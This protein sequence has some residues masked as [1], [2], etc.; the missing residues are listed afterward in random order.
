MPCAVAFGY[1]AMLTS[2]IPSRDNLILVVTPLAEEWHAMRPRLEDPRDEPTASVPVTVGRI[3]SADVVLA[4]SGKGQEHT[5]AIVTKLA[6]QYL[7]RYV[8]LVGVSGGFPKAA[9]GDV[10]IPTFV[11]SLD[12]GKVEQSAFIRRPELDYAP[13]H[14]LV[15]YAKNIIAD[16]RQNWTDTIRKDRPDGKARSATSVKVGYVASSNKVIDDPS[17]PAVAEALASTPE[18]LAVEMEA[19]GAWAAVKVLQSE[20]LIGLLMVR[21]IS[22]MPGDS[23]TATGAGTDSRLH[24]KPYAADS[25][26]AFA[27]AVIRR[28]FPVDPASGKSSRGSGV[29]DAEASLERTLRQSILAMAEVIR[30]SGVGMLGN[31][32]A[33]SS[34]ART[35][36]APLV[37][38][39]ARREKRI[40][41]LKRAVV[42]RTWTAIVGPHGSGKTQLAALLARKMAEAHWFTE[43]DFRSIDSFVHQLRLIAKEPASGSALYKLV[44]AQCADGALFVFDDFPARD[45]RSEII[46][47]LRD[48][49]LLALGRVH[50][51]S[52]TA[53]P[54]PP[55]IRQSLSR[56]DFSTESTLEFD[57]AEARELLAAHGAPPSLPDNFIA[58]LNARA[59]GNA[60]LLTAAAEY[61]AARN[62][63]VDGAAI[64]Q[65]L[66]GSH[67]SQLSPD[68]L[69][70]LLDDVQD[71][72]ARELFNRLRLARYPIPDDV[73]RALAEIPPEVTRPSERLLPLEGLWVRRPDPHHVSVAPLADALP[74]PDLASK[75]A[76]SCHVL[77]G[78]ISFK[79]TQVDRDDV[80]DALT[81]FVAAPDLN[82]AAAVVYT[83][84]VSL[85]AQKA[86]HETVIPA[87]WASDPMPSGIDLHLRLFIRSQQLR[88]ARQQGTPRDFLLADSRQLLEQTSKD[89]AWVVALFMFHLAITESPNDDHLLSG[90][91]WDT[92]MSAAETLTR[93]LSPEGEL[94]SDIQGGSGSTKHVHIPREAWTLSFYLVGRAANNVERAD[95]WTAAV[96][97]LPA[98][99]RQELFED[100]DAQSLLNSGWLRE[101][102]REN[103]ATAL[104]TVVAVLERFAVWSEQKNPTLWAYAVRAL[105]IVH[106][107]LL[108]DV[109][110]ALAVGEAAIPKATTPHARFLIREEVGTQL[111]LNGDL[112]AAE[113]WFLAA[114][115]DRSSATVPEQII[116]LQRTASVLAHHQSSA[117]VPLLTEAADIVNR[118]AEDAYA[119]HSV[120][121]LGDLGLAHW[122]D[123]N[124]KEAFSAWESAVLNLTGERIDET[125]RHGL[126]ALLRSAMYYPSLSSK[127]GREVRPQ[128]MGDDFELPV[129]GFFAGNV[130]SAHRHYVI[131][132]EANVSLQLAEIAL[133]LSK[134]D[135]AS[136]WLDS[137]IASAEAINNPAILAEVAP[138][139]ISF[140]I[141]RGDLVAVA[142]NLSRLSSAPDDVRRS[143]SSTLLAQYGFLIAFYLARVLIKEPS[144]DCKLAAESI[145]RI[146]DGLPDE[147]DAPMFASVFTAAS[148]PEATERL[149]AMAADE[150]LP[151]L[152]A[153]T[154]HLLLSCMYGRR[155]DQKAADHVAL[156]FEAHGRS[157]LWR[158]AYAEVVI[159]FFIEFWT[160]ETSANP[161]R[162][163]RPDDVRREIAS[164]SNLADRDTLQRLLTIV[165][166]S[167]GVRVPEPYRSWLR[168]RQTTSP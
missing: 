94:R 168:S 107:E 76:Y 159:P 28:L 22:D 75:T 103:N 38:H 70:M 43:T 9:Y 105:I 2:P 150:S 48:F 56:D 166:D 147:V 81:H 118:H 119:W 139:A 54:I 12:F 160:R 98:P 82:R 167:V 18:I 62:W 11:H 14:R 92:A 121:I 88:I 83:A 41:H 20:R 65:I 120:T 46:A 134:R 4:Q 42:S 49:A 111:R 138:D 16:E 114:L 86:W 55:T 63:A 124:R 90:D 109:R 31:V 165:V 95:R 3:G 93:T 148:G 133:A 35:E 78:D 89:D 58:F 126:L 40:D 25:A 13:D 19:I 33:A 122:Y 52:L 5:A 100:L 146:F 51:L 106:N 117:A 8:I 1:P 66:E 84:L 127:L 141:A 123:G 57:D 153:R 131:G 137:A 132:S 68:V 145:A 149:A 24:W 50:I 73:V 104:R 71:N 39:L 67:L 74:K 136:R 99:R 21:G 87:I 59:H 163:T 23:R 144:E 140:A 130:R 61:L 156:G 37:A 113:P 143:G 91:E 101:A 79:K 15:E 151:T 10:V 45:A 128:E 69:S 116:A 17:H 30:A 110:T 53:T 155:T 158:P 115:P 102:K 129:V 112:G 97:A 7:P 96:D 6:N 108:H 47:A 64:V 77:L 154:A 36:A 125:L 34:T 157:N 60:T 26:A 44:I 29:V 152:V 162:F 27:E 72:D 80:L 164:V 32:F 135:H 85:S 142:A 161:F